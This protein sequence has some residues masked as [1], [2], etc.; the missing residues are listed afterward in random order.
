MAED[1]QNARLAYRINDAAVAIGLSRSKLYQLI[2]EGRL[3]K[4][5]LAGRTLIRAE[6]LKRLLDEGTL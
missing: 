1:Q 4:T 2:N 6:E 3:Q 5:S